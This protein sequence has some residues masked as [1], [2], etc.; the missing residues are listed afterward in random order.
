MN[1]LTSLEKLCFDIAMAATERRILIAKV[2][3][4][5]QKSESAHAIE[6]VMARA[7]GRRCRS[8]GYWEYGRNAHKPRLRW[9]HWS[10]A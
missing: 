10:L 8:L 5:A 9:V 1:G 2:R 3:V 7:E 6:A 4:A